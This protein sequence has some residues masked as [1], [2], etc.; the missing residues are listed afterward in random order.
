MSTLIH[1]FLARG[2]VPIRSKRIIISLL[3]VLS[4]GM[5]STADHLEVLL[6]HLADQFR[7]GG[8]KLPSNLLIGLGGIT[9]EKLDLSWTEVLGIDSNQDA[10]LVVGINTNLIDGASLA[11][12]LDGSAN[13]C[14][15]T[16]D[17]FTNGMGLSGGQDV[18]IGLILLKHAPHTLDVVA[19][20]APITLGVD[21]SEVEAL[22]DALMDAG[23]GGGD[24]TGDEGLATA[25]T[26]VVEE[27]AVGKVHAVSLTVV[28]K[29]PEGVLLGDSIGR[30]GVEGGGLGLGNLADLAV[31]LGGGGLVEFDLLLH[32]AGADGIEHAEDANTIGIGGVLGHIEGNL[33]V[34]HGTEVVDF[35]G[36]DLG[37][38]GDQISSIAEIAV[39]KE[40]LNASGVTILVKV[41][42]ATGVEGRRT[43]DDAVDGISFL[44]KEL[45]KVR[46][47]LAGDAG[48]EG[49]LLVLVGGDFSRHAGSV[50]VVGRWSK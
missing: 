37:D 33:D 42:N 2:L 27:D 45:G 9:E 12:P 7:E 40:E 38:D 36:A 30:T 23:D 41:I 44:E 48:D 17:E 13:N 14:E 49:D 1:I 16:L 24:L 8:A 22:V 11:L 15:G 4:L 35:G 31:Q 10:I 39:V 47:I 26:L 19:G 46:S 25:G 28:H 29:D 5:P 3:M 34:R 50:W 18:V 6:D 43:T 20:M 32:A 21:V